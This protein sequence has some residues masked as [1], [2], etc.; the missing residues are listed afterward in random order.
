M[1]PMV[2]PSK[3]RYHDNRV[4]NKA[5]CELAKLMSA[6]QV[7]SKTVFFQD[8]FIIPITIQNLAYGGQ[9]GTFESGRGYS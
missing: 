3:K 5:R 1:G 9:H 4:G 7:S 6:G 8:Y 2:N